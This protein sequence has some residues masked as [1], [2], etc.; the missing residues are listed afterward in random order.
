MAYELV[1][2]TR[3]W[4]TDA[5]SG[6]T[7]LLLHGFPLDGRMWDDLVPLLTPTRRVIT[8][9]LRGFGQSDESPAFTMRQ[10]AFDVAGF[11]TLKN[12]APVCVAGL[13]MGGYVAQELA[14]EKP[15]LLSHLILLDTK[16]EPDNPEAQNKRIAMAK[17]VREQGAKAV[18]D[19]MMPNMLATQ[20]AP[21][22]EQKLRRIMESQRVETIAHAC[23]AMRDREDYLSTISSLSIPVDMIVGQHD[24]ISSP[25]LM[26]FMH[27]KVNYGRLFEIP[28]AG[29][30]TPMENPQATASAILQ[31]TENLK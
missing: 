4:Y 21:E 29:H 26:R 14:S 11:I 22:V 10:L 30:I 1:Q 7:I 12:L 8:L 24:A 3:L 16:A 18:A 15:E 17:L 23:I 6:P 19:Q 5:G 25:E 2:S 28:N 13:S 31:S 9:D 20:H 27:A